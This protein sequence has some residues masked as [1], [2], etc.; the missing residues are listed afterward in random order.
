MRL[1]PLLLLLVGALPAAA[2][3]APAPGT[4]VLGTAQADLNVN[5]VAAR[6]FNTGSLFYGNTTT[7]GNGYLVP[8]A[9]GRSAVFASGLWVGGRV[10][11]ELRVAGGTYGAGALDF[12]FWP[13]PLGTDGRPVNPSDCSGYDE[14]FSVTRADITN[15]EAGNP[16]GD[17][18]TWP[19]E[20][21]APVVDGDGNPDNYNLA[22]GD[23]PGIIGDQGLWWVMNDVGNVHPAQNTPPLGIEV[24]VLAFSFARPDALGNTTFYKYRIINKSGTDIEDTYVSVFSDPDLGDAVDDYVGS[25]VAAGLGYVYNAD[26]S[27]AVYGVPPAVGYDFFQ[28]PIVPDG[29]DAGADPDTLSASAFSYFRNTTGGSSDPDNGVQ[30]YNYQQGLWDD[31]SVMRAYGSGYQETQGAITKFAFP[32]DPVTGQ[33]WSERNPRGTGTTSPNVPTDRRFALHT[34]PFTLSNGAAQDVVFGIV[35]AQ[36]T[37]NLNSITALRAADQLAQATFDNDFNPP[38]V[39]GEEASGPSVALAVAP[40][41]FTTEARVSVSAA[42]GSDVH[43]VL[44]DVLGREVAVIHEGPL[45]GELRVPGAGLTPGVY[46]LR[47]RTA[48]GERTVRLVR[49]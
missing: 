2:Q 5:N 43:A 22:G 8:Q 3:T 13:G 40:N 35:F 18:L 34:G 41:P 23:R 19:W 48:D 7:S 9:S 29:P 39:A 1:A 44:L 37:S 17:V 16:T 6:V 42:P 21:G 32:G 31:G 38:P 49:R 15:Y 12:T 28:G 10:G 36:G 4:C 45:S 27:D 33:A 47:V 25:D 14:I 20:L 30:I 11:G 26:N 46:L 24:R